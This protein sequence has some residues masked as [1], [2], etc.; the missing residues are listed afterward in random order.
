MLTLSCRLFSA[1]VLAALLA[2]GAAGQQKLLDRIQPAQRPAGRVKTSSA[3]QEQLSDA[4]ALKRANLS[5]TNG[6]KLIEYLKQ[7]TLTESEQGR[8]AEIIKRFGADDFD[9][10]VRATQEIESYG[11]A[12]IGPLKPAASD[13]DPEVAFRARQALKKVETVPHSAVASAAVKAVAKLKPD[14]AAAALIGFLPLADDE[15]VSDVI[16]DALVSLA[17]GADGKA[18]PALVAAL[19]DVSPIRRAAAYKA[20][21]T[22]GPSTERIRVKD[23][24]PRV[25]EAVLKESDTEARFTGLWALALTTRE[26]EFIPE[27]IAL[28]P[29]LPRGRIWQVE[30]LLLQLAGTHPKDGRFLKS[31]ESLAKAGDAWQAWWKEKGDSIDLAKLDYKQRVAGITDLLEMDVR[32]SGP[33][34]LISLGHDLKERWRI[35]GLRTPGDARFAPN[36]R[37]YVLETNYSTVNEMDQ[38]GKSIRTINVGQQPVTANLLP[39][40]GLLVICR[41]SVFAFDEDG[42]QL[43]NYNRPSKRHDI[44]AGE[45]LPSGEVVLITNNGQDKATG[46]VLD[47]KL[48]ETK[49]KITLGRTYHVHT[50]DVIGA[51][52]VLVCESTGVAEYDIETGKQEW[53]FA[54]NSPTSCQRLINGNTLICEMNFIPNGRVIEVD[55][56][57]EIVWEYQSK[58]S[59]RIGRAYRR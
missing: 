6:A 15:A 20:L 56:S 28:V 31:P 29:K 2:V 25:R 13:S 46:V 54:C 26:K 52:K 1:A 5:E 41:G 12:A 49:R 50:M 38:T 14:G 42:K 10:R 33:G 9:E 3:V 35:T 4:E 47:E 19:A 43:L 57:G 48:K 53:R 7:R 55:P 8:I 44:L 45:R 23:A 59:L 36:G 58:D 11:P 24:Y 21:I 32:Y 51:N 18:D 16:R 27:L 22:G 17:I 39:D 30:D 40:G 34:R 37:I